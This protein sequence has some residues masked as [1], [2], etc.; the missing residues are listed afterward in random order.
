LTI[1]IF[2]SRSSHS[3]LSRRKHRGRKPPQPM[4]CVLIITV[5]QLSTR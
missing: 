1:H 3:Q 2:L 4:T 5:R